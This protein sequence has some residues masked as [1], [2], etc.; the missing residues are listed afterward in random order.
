M[1]DNSKATTNYLYPNAT[2]IVFCKAPLPGQVK[3]R[4]LPTI[5]AECA[6]DIHIKLTH[7]T[8]NLVTSTNLCSVQLWCGSNIKH[9]FFA[10]CV[11]KY[12][13]SLHLQQGVDLGMRMQHA[14]ANSLSKF[15]SA[16]IIGCDCP[17]LTPSHLTSALTE[18]NNTID[19][20]LAPTQD[21]GYALIGLNQNQPTLFARINWGGGEVLA[22][23]K[24][25]IKKLKLAY[26]QLPEQ[27]D[28]DTPKDLARYL[29]LEP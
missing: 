29:L 12:D 11:R 17:S 9:A 8:L 28:V 2:I 18:L 27:W 13:V 25:K 21:G 14:F 15:K 3:T 16:L 6:T 22:N 1:P 10:T 4:L 20:V 23:T 19:V 26:Y 7:Q 24:N 5:N